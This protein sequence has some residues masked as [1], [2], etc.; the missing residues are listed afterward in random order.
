M[1]NAKKGFSD[2]HITLSLKTRSEL[3]SANTACQHKK[4]LHAY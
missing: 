4:Y 1:E 3:K 2:S